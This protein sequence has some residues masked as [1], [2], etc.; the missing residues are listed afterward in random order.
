MR[1][2]TRSQFPAALL[3]TAALLMPVLCPAQQT[4]PSK[5]I[6]IVTP[7]AP[8]GA[9]TLL[10]R[11]VGDKM[12]EDWGQQVLVDNRPGGNSLIGTEIVARA[13]PDGH[14]L[15]LITSGHVINDVLLANL[16]Y[17]TNRDF[18]PVSPLAGYE[19]ALL[20][21]P[22]LKVNTLKEL[23][24]LLK[25]RPNELN[26]AIA[27]SS[28]GSTHLAGE[29]FKMLTGTQWTSVNYK[30]TGPVL[31]ALMSGEV[32]VHITPPALY[33][34]AIKAGKIRAL[35][36]GGDKRLPSLP[37]VPTF[38]EAGVPGYEYK[39]WYG[40]LAPGQTPRPIVEKISTE[41]QKILS[42]PEMRDRL[43]GQEM[44]PF[45]MNPTAFKAFLVAETAKYA[46]IVKAGNIKVAE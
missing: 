37:D 1:P 17:D 31:P 3:A 9:T 29:H 10:G 21:T 25:A 20:V 11:L 13:T 12:T 36:V 35:A 26:Y 43:V 42:T 44:E 46:K 34:S 38:T 27:G 23:L 32:Q 39:G 30:G 4:F 15:L 41:I 6:R 19:P 28:G 45:V 40:V 2:I 5:P 33:L 7:Y 24:A 8:G 18:A 16:P 14:T 22:S